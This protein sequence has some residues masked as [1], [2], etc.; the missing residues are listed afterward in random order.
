MSS[1]DYVPI[2]LFAESLLYR[3]WAIAAVVT[4]AAMLSSIAGFAFAA[5]AGSVMFH[6][7]DDAAY[8]VQIMIVASIGTQITGVLSIRRSIDWRAVCPF[9]IGGALTIVPGVYLLFHIAPQLYLRAIGVFLAIYG[10]C[11]LFRRPIVISMGG[12]RSLLADLFVGSL[13]GIMAPLAA[14]PG[15]FISIWC[16][17]RGWDKLRQ[18]AIYQPYILV[19]QIASLHLIHIATASGGYDLFLLLYAL[20]AVVGTH[21][22]LRVFQQLTNT[23]FSKVLNVFIILSGLTLAAGSKS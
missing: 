11:M 8:A 5:F 9:L 2:E 20:P 10:A 3:Y 19:M 15:A 14:F 16:G 6:L 21:L 17:M 22:G 13:G 4:L 18:R 23:Q 12:S 7:V 1:F